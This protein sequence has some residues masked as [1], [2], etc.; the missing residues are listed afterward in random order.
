[1]DVF[2]LKTEIASLA[3]RSGVLRRNTEQALGVEIH[4]LALALEQANPTPAP[5]QRPQLY[6][7]RWQLLYSTFD[8]EPQTNLRRLSFNRLPSAA[9]SV[10]RLYQ[11]VDP[12]DGDDTVYDNVVELTDPSG[13]TLVKVM[14]GRYAAH[15]GHRLDVVFH[16]VFV[17]ATDGRPEARLRADLGLGADARLSVP[18][19]RTPPMHSS[20]VFLD[21]ELRINRGVYGGLYVLRRVPG[22]FSLSRSRDP[23]RTR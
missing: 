5:A 22:P 10:A 7:G 15:D 14:L 16:H 13:G 6:A 20:I 12:G 1:M 17:T 11:E 2:A 19:E 21:D 23:A 8:L 4:A 18:V 3:E 9:V